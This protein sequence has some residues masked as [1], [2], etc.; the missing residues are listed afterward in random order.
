MDVE[1]PDSVVDEL[2]RI[3]LGTLHVGGNS[4]SSG[5]LVEQHFA[6][7]WRYRCEWSSV[8]AAHCFC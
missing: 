7:V 8:D 6:V 2:F 5:I 1:V 3:S 4:Y